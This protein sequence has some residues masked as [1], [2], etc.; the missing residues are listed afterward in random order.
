M[1]ED[2]STRLCD[3]E[4]ESA[5]HV[6][7][8]EAFCLPI[9]KIP[10]QHVGNTDS[11]SG[12]HEDSARQSPVPLNIASRDYKLLDHPD[13]R[14]RCPACGQKGSDYIEKLTPERK[15]RADQTALRICKV[16]YKTALKR[17][18]GERP[19]LPGILAIGRMVRISKDIGRC[20]VCNRGKAVYHDPEAGTRVCQQCYDRE[21]R[22]TGPA[23]GGAG[24]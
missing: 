13:Y 4:C 18:Q 5:E 8:N 12:E 23:E 3:C 6:T 21:A 11:T 14:A 19:P 1:T 17:E 2:S 9:L 16:C 24:R 10:A 20:S 15:A 7:V 22:A